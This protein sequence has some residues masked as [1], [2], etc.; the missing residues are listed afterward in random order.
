MTYAL[1]HNKE[2][3]MEKTTGKKHKTIHY[4]NAEPKPQKN[5]LADKKGNIFY[6]KVSQ[7]NSKHPNACTDNLA[8]YI[9]VFVF[10]D[11]AFT[12]LTVGIFQTV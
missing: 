5:T 7:N 9:I 3:K 2:R 12:L 4:A 11:F 8:S 1:K 10:T 6:S